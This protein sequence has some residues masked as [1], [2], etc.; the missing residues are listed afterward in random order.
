MSLRYVL[1]LRSRQL[2]QRRTCRS[3]PRLA[4]MRVKL[5]ENISVRL[6]GELSTLGCDVDTVASERLKGKPDSDVSSAAR[7]EERFLI[8]QDLDFSDV[9]QFKP[10]T[11]AGLLRVRLREPGANALVSRIHAALQEEDSFARCFVVLTDRK[12]RIRR[13]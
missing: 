1:S 6:A 8:T 5:D 4:C 11:H 9:R 3:P 2:P 12:L 13:P 7:R 10:G